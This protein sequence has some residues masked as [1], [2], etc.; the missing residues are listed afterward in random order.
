MHLR[1]RIARPFATWIARS[2]ILPLSLVCSS[3]VPVATAT[4]A[5]AP[6]NEKPAASQDAGSPMSIPASRPA[7][8][9]IQSKDAFAK[10]WNQQ[11]FVGPGTFDLSEGAEDTPGAGLPA[12]FER[13]QAIVLAGGWLAREAPDVLAEVVGRAGPRA[14]LVLLVSSSEEQNLVVRVLTR[15]GVRS[16]P[17]KFVTAAADTGWVRDFG[18]IFTRS[19]EGDL[20]A[21]DAAYDMQGRDHDDSAARAI[22]DA[23]RVTTTQTQFRWQ[24]GNLLSNG[25]GL[26]VTTTQSLNANIECGHD[27]ETLKRFLKERFGVKQLV[28]LE[29]LL[30]ERTGHA[31]MFACFTSA[32]TIVIG[33]CDE[34]IDPANAAVLDRNAERLSA[35]RIGEARLKVIRV[36]MPAGQDALWRSHTNVVF[37]DGVLLVPIYPSV[38]RASGEEAMAVFR[39]LLPDWKVIAVDATNMA[40]HQ[41]GLRCVTLYVPEA[42]AGSRQE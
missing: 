40:K 25:E 27:V 38:D 26:L 7:P 39:R 23:F 14:R 42:G 32:D 17:G 13:H 5:E 29:H 31:D 33:R 6:S 34:S 19:A 18:P 20:L 8:D 9:L 30:G 21:F 35:V 2:L 15:A 22:A 1:P 28:V 37:A 36:R 3:A 16:D 24:G 12:D 41:G 11:W 4:E 10:L